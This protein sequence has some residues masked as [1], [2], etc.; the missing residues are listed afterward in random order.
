MPQQTWR[1]C[2]ASHCCALLTWHHRRPGPVRPAPPLTEVKPSHNPA[3][4][5]SSS[6]HFSSSSYLS[7]SPSVRYLMLTPTHLTFPAHA[8]FSF[9]MISSTLPLHLFRTLASSLLG[10]GW[11]RLLGSRDKWGRWCWSFVP[12]WAAAVSVPRIMMQPSTCRNR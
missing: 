11:C 7:P 4:N 2:A 12:V 8:A 1:S 5:S 3:H 10:S 6:A 9:L